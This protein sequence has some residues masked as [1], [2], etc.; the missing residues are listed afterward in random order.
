V[1]PL[2]FGSSLGRAQVVLRL[3]DSLG[4]DQDPAQNRAVYPESGWWLQR[5]GDFTLCLDF[6]GVGLHGQG[7]HAHNDDFSFCLEWLARPVIVDPGTFVYTSDPKARNRF[8]STSFH[9]TVAV[10]GKEQREL[11]SDVFRLPGPD[12]AFRAT[13]LPDQAWAFTRKLGNGLSHS[14]VIS[15]GDRRFVIRDELEG[16]GTH[17]LRWHF[18]LHPSVQPRVIPRGFAL[19]VPG[20]GT[21]K[22]ETSLPSPVFELERSEYSPGYGRSEPTFACNASGKFALPLSAEWS[23]RPE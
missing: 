18:H 19:A 13:P 5:A 7:G 15:S 17:E 11:S 1:L 21:L 20:A 9:N 8:R 22:L 14:R 2:D 16:S 4:L 12:Q 3:A 23:L 6:G 10:D